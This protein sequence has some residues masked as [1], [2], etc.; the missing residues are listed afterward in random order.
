VSQAEALFTNVRAA[1][2]AEALFRAHERIDM[3]MNRI[4]GGWS[5]RISMDERIDV[6]NEHEQTN[7][8]NVML[9]N[10]HE[11]CF[12]TLRRA[13]DKYKHPSPRERS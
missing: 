2:I 13:F 3:K 1:S 8:H 9:Q 4:G 5:V 12:E 7:R 6:T 11:D 10:V